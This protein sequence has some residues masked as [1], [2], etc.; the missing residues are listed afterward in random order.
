V[1]TLLAILALAVLTDL[2]FYTGFFASDDLQYAGGAIQ[3]AQY[4][5]LSYIT[6][7]AIS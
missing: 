3:L 1:W 4:G 7:E 6:L 5:R 2:I